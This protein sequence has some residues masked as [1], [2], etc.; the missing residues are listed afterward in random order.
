MAALFKK[1]ICKTW[2]GTL[3]NSADPDQTPQKAA[4]DQGLYCLRK[5]QELRSK[6][7]SLTFPFRTIFPA[8]TQR[9]SIQQCC[10]CFD[11]QLLW[12]SVWSPAHQALSVNWS[13]LKWNNFS[14]CF[15]FRTA[16]LSEGDKNIFYRVASLKV[17]PFP[18]SSD[19]GQSSQ[20]PLSSFTLILPR[21]TRTWSSVA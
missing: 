3:A 16:R 7:N 1:A 17:P 13:T 15:P 12:L 20:R 4:S 2:T 18:F 6:R 19:K 21:Y 10:Q 11:S 8:Y 5:L 14:K 9:E